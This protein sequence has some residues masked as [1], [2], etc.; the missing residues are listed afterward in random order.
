MSLRRPL[1]RKRLVVSG[2]V[3]CGGLLLFTSLVSLKKKPSTEYTTPPTSSASVTHY[4][5]FVGLSKLQEH[6]L[7]ERQIKLVEFGFWLYSD[8]NNKPLHEVILYPN[9]ISSPKNNVIT[10]GVTIDGTE[11]LTAEIKT[12]Q[13][14]SV[15]MLLYGDGP[16]PVFDTG[17]LLEGDD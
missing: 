15:Q 7:S 13:S 2:L 16:S 3:L 8:K 6:G 17:S 9:T 14:G 10:C 1:D 5:D 11:D 4:K 12:G